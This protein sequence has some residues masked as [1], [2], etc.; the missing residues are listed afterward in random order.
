MLG[1]SR[2]VSLAFRPRSHLWPSGGLPQVVGGDVHGLDDALVRELG[3]VV[4]GP[5]RLDRRPLEE[6]EARLFAGNEGR[7]QVAYRRSLV[8][9]RGRGGLGGTG[10]R[11]ELFRG[12]PRQVPFNE[13]LAHGAAP[14]DTPGQTLVRQR[15][16]LCWVTAQVARVEAAGESII[17]GTSRFG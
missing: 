12:D 11:G 7:A 5:H 15:G 3:P 1:N 14:H 2:D 10:G 9:H 8:R 6:T 16:H 17:G 4:G 13:I